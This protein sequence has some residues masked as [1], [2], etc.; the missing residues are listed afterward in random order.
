MPGEHNEWE[1]L[2]AM[3]PDDET[4]LLI[5]GHGVVLIMARS[6][7]N[8]SSDVV[9]FVAVLTWI[10]ISGTYGHPLDLWFYAVV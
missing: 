9:V 4:T 7:Q 1:M 6:L 2:S 8:L 3:S 5:V 10:N